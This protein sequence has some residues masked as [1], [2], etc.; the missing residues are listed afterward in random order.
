MLGG[1]KD[2]A[3]GDKLPTLSASGGNIVFAFVR[4]QASIDGSTT[5]VIEVGTTPG[6]W[7]D[8]HPVPDGLAAAN[9]GVTVTKDHPAAGRDTVTLSLPMNEATRRFARL[10]VM[11]R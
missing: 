5:L 8:I 10:K 9:P 11:V 1:T 2:T 4:D 7:A 6:L 3:D